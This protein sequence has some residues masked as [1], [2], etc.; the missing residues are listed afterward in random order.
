MDNINIKK[1]Y[2]SINTTSVKIID[3]YNKIDNE[4]LNTQPKYQRKLVWKKQHK[5][6]FIDT[7]LLNFPFPE[8]YIA[9][10]EIDVERMVATE[11]VVD[12]QQRLT[13]IVEY[14]KGIGD[15][16][17]QK[18]VPNFNDL[19]PED[20]KDFLN[21]KV[22]VKDLKDIGED[23]IKEIF[24]RINSTEYSLNTVE[25]NNAQFGDGEIALFCK[26]L[27]DS[28][29]TATEKETDIIIDEKIKSKINTFFN[30]KKI[31]TNNDIK[32]MYDFQFAMLFTS[33]LLEGSYFGRNSKVDEYIEKFNYSFPDY[34][35]VINKLLESIDAVLKLDFSIKSYWYNKANLFTLIIEFSKIDLAKLDYQKL[36]LE[37]LS[38]EDKFDLYFSADTEEDLRDISE[39]E[40]KYFQVARQGSHEK[41]SR[42]HRGTL[43]AKILKDC[44]TINKEENK[45]DLKVKNIKLLESSSINFAKLIPTKTGLNKNIMDAVSGVRKFLKNNE[46]HDYDNQELG[47]DHKI[48]LECLFLFKDKSERSEVSLYRSNGRGDYRLWFKD[49][50]TFAKPNDELAL[51]K[52]DGILNVLNMSTIYYN[53]FF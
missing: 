23:V 8:V 49:L 18:R 17:N 43:I 3:L 52:R 36:E 1:L 53:G 26:Q 28:N 41:A 31:F 37:L 20:K 29:Y 38:L 42:E 2:E 33:T 11:V 16:T 35:I 45:G 13:T 7:I 15:F 24:Q 5:Y 14:I 44:I 12:G 19:K 9:S 4:L 34:T 51:I 46:L 30:E 48:K 10:S 22:S 50:K 47:P 27:I 25:K 39:D 32:R 21:Y 6:A 40:K